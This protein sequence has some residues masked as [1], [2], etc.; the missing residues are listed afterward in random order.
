MLKWF[1]RWWFFHNGY[2]N[3]DFFGDHF[4][5]SGYTVDVCDHCGEMKEIP[6]NLYKEGIVHVGLCKGMNNYW[7]IEHKENWH[8]GIDGSIQTA[9]ICGAVLS[10]LSIRQFE[11]LMASDSLIDIGCGTGEAAG[12]F[13]GLLDH[14][15]F[16]VDYCEKA[17]RQ[18]PSRVTALCEDFRN[19]KAR[20][21]IG[22]CSQL[23]AFY[24]DNL[25]SELIKLVN[26]MLIVVV[27]Y[28]QNM[29]G[30]VTEPAEGNEP[31][32]HKRAFSRKD[33]PKF[34]GDFERTTFKPMP[35]TNPRVLG[36]QLL[37]VYEI[38]DDRTK[39]DIEFDQKQ[40]EDYYEY[41][42]NR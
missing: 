10:N 15:V 39:K 30:R 33:F 8:K 19:L 20:Y 17:T 29:D 3:Y 11:K 25:L 16:A 18:A 37:V 23:L 14:D 32:G 27:P 34:L 12:I 42:G 35:V 6:Q 24:K 1:D 22:Y 2:H 31:G 28:D 4:G 21:D 13:D 40:L 41:L 26:E 7:E 36:Q 9:M 38:I 5:P